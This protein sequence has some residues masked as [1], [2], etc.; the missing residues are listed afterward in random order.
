MTSFNRRQRGVSLAVIAALS[1][2]AAC[3]TPG[4]PRAPDTSAAPTIGG[5]YGI[6]HFEGLSA[7]NGYEAVPAAQWTATEWLDLQELDLSCHR[8]M[9]PQIPGLAQEVLLPS[10]KLG[11]M[12]GIF[13]A[14][15]TGF[16]AVKAFT[17][18]SFQ[19][20][21]TY[22][23][24]AGGFS[25]FGSGIASYSDRAKLARRY[26]QYACMQFAV[27]EARRAGRLRGIGIIPNAG[28]SDFRG[29]PMPQG[30]A[31]RGDTDDAPT[32]GTTS[33]ADDSDP[34]MT[35]PL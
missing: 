21:A 8:Q 7:R 16:A 6:Y 28:S 26:V 22:G 31:S 11:V 14:I 19:D 10:F 18:V 13:G 29:I 23:G 35:P 33:P 27:S 9:D 20:Y 24:V 1:L 15:G 3:T 2:T 4:G 32:T 34:P 25:A 17:G 5:A 12:T 30:P